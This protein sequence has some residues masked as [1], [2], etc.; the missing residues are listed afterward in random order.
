MMRRMFRHKL[1]DIYMVICIFISVMTIF[2]GVDEYNKN[3][4]LLEDEETY[5]YRYAC[6]IVLNRRDLSNRDF[7]RIDFEEIKGLSDKIN[8]FAED[9]NAYV[10][11]AGLTL[12][13]RIIGLN[14][15]SCFPLVKGSYDNSTVYKNPSVIVGKAIYETN[16]KS[17]I[18]EIDSV[19]YD[20]VG[21]MASDKT[22]ILD[23]K[24]YV[25]YSSED[26]KTHELFDNYSTVFLG[27]Y[28]MDSAGYD[29]F[30]KVEKYLERYKDDW[31]IDVSSAEGN[32]ANAG[33][34]KTNEMLQYAL[35]FFALLNTVFAA[36]LWVRVRMDKIVISKVYGMSDS[37]VFLGLLKEIL[38]VTALAGVICLVILLIY[39]GFTIDFREF[40]LM[41]A[42][43]PFTAMIISFVPMFAIRRKSLR[44]MLTEAEVM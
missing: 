44:D 24:I 43:V 7:K 1:V 23:H 19:T 13:D 34:D 9:C 28:A 5:S 40:V 11:G 14:D 6:Q 18:I 42:S 29:D 30:S 36:I 10:D 17:D 27:L 31:S 12:I 38:A 41:I 35:Y 33:V 37:D 25:I 21:V 2:I 20:I 4:K 16:G 3:I 39:T 15:K 8:I 26:K 22:D 32:I